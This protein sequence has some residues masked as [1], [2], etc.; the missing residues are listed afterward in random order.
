MKRDNLQRPTV[1]VVDSD[2]A[3]RQLLRLGLEVDGARVLESSSP[4]HARELLS[5]KGGAALV[6]GVVVAGDLPDSGAARV[7]DEVDRLLPDIPVVTTVAPDGGALTGLEDRSPHVV[8]GDLEA[9]I[10]ALRL[11][12]ELR[13]ATRPRAADLL[14]DDAEAV[15]EAWRELCRWDPLLGPDADP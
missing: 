10:S 2:P 12:V 13:E 6:C 11:P 5:A 3:M 9:V 14:E 15:A 8:R 4:D 1:L 7:H